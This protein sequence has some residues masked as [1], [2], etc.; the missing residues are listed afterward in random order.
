MK[1]S[2]LSVF[3]GL[4]IVMTTLG[5]GCAPGPTPEGPLEL[6][7]AT[8]DLSG[9]HDI[10]PTMQAFVDEVNASSDVHLQFHYSEASLKFE[11]LVNGLEEGTYDMII[12]T[13]SYASD[14]WP[15]MSVTALPFIFDDAGHLADK[16]RADGQLR[17][18]MD[19]QLGKNH[20]IVIVA[21]G[22]LPLAYLWTATGPVRDPEDMKGMRIRVAGTVESETVTSLGASPVVMPSEVLSISEMGHF[23]NRTLWHD[24]AALTSSLRPRL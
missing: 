1:T 21:S 8:R 6:N 18:L 11:E 5:A 2:I 7:I 13:S 20:D 23:L 14:V 16:T 10:F 17:K 24:Q 4:L 15:V 9:Y 19:E 12:I 22:T 3:I